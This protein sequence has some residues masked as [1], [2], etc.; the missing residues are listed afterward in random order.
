VNGMSLLKKIKQGK[1]NFKLIDFPS[2]D[3]KVAI[4]AL[5]SSQTT[6]AHLDAEEIIKEYGIEDEDMKSLEHQKQLAYRFIREKDDKTK[7][8][9]DS[10]QEFNEAMTNTEIQYFSM[11]YSM[12]INENSPFL[13]AV[14]EEQFE[15]LKK[16][17]EKIQLKDLNGV[18]L[19]ALRNFLLTLA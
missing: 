14:N 4:V 6:Q 16:T 12:F 13:N 10:F 1:S 17:L 11:Q 8:I 19:V 18:S 15:A 7:A 3:E 5:S 2:I 9:A